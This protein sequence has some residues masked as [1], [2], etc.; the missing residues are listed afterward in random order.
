MTG[1]AALLRLNLQ[2]L[3]WLA[4]AYAAASAVVTA[5]ALMSDDPVIPVTVSLFAAVFM[6]EMVGAVFK[7]RDFG[8]RSEGGGWR[9]FVVTVVDRR[10][11]VTSRNL[12]CLVIALPSMILAAIVSFVVDAMTGTAMLACA[13]LFLLGAVFQNAWYLNGGS[14][15]RSIRES[16]LL[17][18]GH[19]Y[20]HY[21][22]HVT[23]ITG[24]VGGGLLVLA[25][26]L[27][28][29]LSFTFGWDQGV[30]VAVFV[31]SAGMVAALA[32]H[33]YTVSFYGRIDQ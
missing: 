27:G 11:L 10:D 21:S 26:V 6:V 18:L 23:A 29:M 28:S 14:I 33:A 4:V 22:G 30:T 8:V 13:T 31:A 3:R 1:V 7:V 16:E 9:T 12:S 20:G 2:S 19:R 24:T 5:V 25:L 15:Y 17:G 32:I